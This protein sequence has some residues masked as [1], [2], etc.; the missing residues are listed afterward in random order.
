MVRPPDTLAPSPVSPSSPLLSFSFNVSSHLTGSGLRPPPDVDTHRGDFFFVVVLNKEAGKH[1]A[2]VYRRYLKFLWSLVWET[3][4]PSGHVTQR[5]GKRE[6]GSGGPFGL[7]VG[8]FV[9]ETIKV[10]AEGRFSTTE[11]RICSGS[12]PNTITK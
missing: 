5:W 8:G 6:R 2:S 4:F 12:F 9:V 1:A 11:K 3:V 10:D 7:D